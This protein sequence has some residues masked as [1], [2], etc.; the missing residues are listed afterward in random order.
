MIA[1]KAMTCVVDEAAA[2]TIEAPNHDCGVS[3]GASFAGNSDPVP[4]AS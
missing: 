2:E 4:T 1:S 3:C